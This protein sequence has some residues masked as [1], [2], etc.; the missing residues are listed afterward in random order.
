VL[1]EELLLHHA[2]VASLKATGEGYLL[3]NHLDLVSQERSVRVGMAPSV[4]ST[5][6]PTEHICCCCAAVRALQLGLS[7]VPLVDPRVPR[8]L[9]DYC[10]I[11]RSV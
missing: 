9:A 2:N 5:A 6:V 7:V 3:L 8:S 1:V 10:V 11:Y 4:V